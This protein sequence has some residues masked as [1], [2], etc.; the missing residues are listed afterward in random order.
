MRL[1]NAQGT[2]AAQ[3]LTSSADAVSTTHPLGNGIPKGGEGDSFESML[4]ILYLSIPNGIIISGIGLGIMESEG[5]SA[6]LENARKNLRLTLLASHPHHNRLD[7]PV[8]TRSNGD[9]DI[10]NLRLSAPSA[11]DSKHCCSGSSKS[12]KERSRPCESKDFEEIRAAMGSED[13]P[14]GVKH[15]SHSP[16]GSFWSI[17]TAEGRMW[18]MK[19]VSAQDPHSH[20]VLLDELNALRRVRCVNGLPWL[21]EVDSKKDD[22]LI[23]MVSPIDSMV[24]LEFIL[25]YI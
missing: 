22:T 1:V 2:S 20:Q 16:G 15:V 25:S 18:T 9:T 23:L 5:A 12:V 7:S 17:S 21:E 3:S 6:H 14:H 11:K 8:L 19:K 13:L 4:Y 24:Q 10:Q